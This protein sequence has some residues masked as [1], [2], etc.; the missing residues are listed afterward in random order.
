MAVNALDWPL[1]HDRQSVSGKVVC[2][3]HCSAEDL[4]SWTT[5][6]R[7][8]WPSAMHRHRHAQNGDA[9]QT[10]SR[11]DAHADDSYARDLYAADSCTTL[12][13]G[14]PSG[15]PGTECAFTEAQDFN[16]YSLGGIDGNGAYNG[17][18]TDVN[19]V[20][21]DYTAAGLNGTAVNV[22][23]LPAIGVFARPQTDT[24]LSTHYHLITIHLS[25]ASV[26]RRMHSGR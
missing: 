7:E 13:K 22:S 15:S 10:A 21:M 12:G 14:T 19:L 24:F 17:L 20:G 8:G 2:K 25:L 1:R 3:G 11:I 23:V 9:W 26:N 5:S 18:A 4:Q 6:N 16:I